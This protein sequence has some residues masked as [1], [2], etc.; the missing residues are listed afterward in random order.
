MP[1]QL[2]ERQIL[3]RPVGRPQSTGPLGYRGTTGESHQRQEE[4]DKQEG[5]R[6]KGRAC[7]VGMG[8]SR[9]AR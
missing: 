1:R 8:T 7:L 3:R 4:E 6:N 9:V 2:D 5:G